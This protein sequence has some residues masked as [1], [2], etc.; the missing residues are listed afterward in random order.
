MSRSCTKHRL[1]PLTFLLCIHRKLHL[2]IY[3]NRTPC[4]CGH[5]DHDTYGYHAFCCERGNKKRAHNII[6]KDF[7]GTLS[8]VLA[9]AG[10]P[11]PNTPMTA[12]PLL[13][14]PSDSTAQPFDISFSPGPT[15]C[16][17]CYCPYTPIGADINITGPPP[18]PKAY[19]PEDILNTIT[20]NADNNLQRH[21]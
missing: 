16:H 15:S 21:E 14:L 20:V 7:S 3:P 8:P 11:Y 17:Y 9:Q 1:T 13:H 5:H 6:D 12:E 19:Q 10:Y 18:T 4:I 2:P